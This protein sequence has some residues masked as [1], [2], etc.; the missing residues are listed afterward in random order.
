MSTT[1]STTAA[2][3]DG[4]GHEAV[5]QET[6]SIS[7]KFLLW[8]SFWI[9]VSTVICVDIALWLLNATEG[10]L[11]KLAVSPPAVPGTYE[12]AGEAGIIERGMLVERRDDKANGE[13]QQL[14]RS[15]DAQL[16]TYGWTDRPRGL[17]RIPIGQAMDQVV[18]SYGQRK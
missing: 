10:S 12:A 9:A 15:Q 5:R 17:I 3:G 14:K 11:G 13:I 6:D 7:L 8:F 18:N 4:H 16:Q 2:H 1:P